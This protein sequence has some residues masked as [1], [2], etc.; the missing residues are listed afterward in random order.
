MLEKFDHPA[1][2]R[3]EQLFARPDWLYELTDTDIGEIDRAFQGVA[4]MDLE[5]ITQEDFSLPR[6]ATRMTAIQQSLESGSGATWVRGFPVERY[7][8]EQ[9][10]RVFWGLSRHVGT[11]VSQ[12]AEGERIFHVRDAGYGDQDPRTRG[13]N[14]RKKLSFHTDRCDVIS[15]LCLKQAKSGGE[16]FL[17]SSLALFN[18]LLERRPDLLQEL[19]RPY[20]YQRHNVDGGNALPYCRQPIFSIFEGH[21][22]ASFLRVLI[23]RAY[24]MPELPEMTDLQREALDYLEQLAEDPALHVRF[25][26]QAGDMLFLNNWVTFHRRSDF[27]DHETPERKRHLLRLWLSVPNSRPLDPQFRENF[28]ATEAGALRGGMRAR[29]A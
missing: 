8:D 16:N 4:Q 13:P 24:R 26:Q 14:T 28:G 22:A 1:A 12:S 19:M 10:M 2:W 25:R 11:P 9:A 20:Y 21:F 17:V 29:S 18:E 23:E 6:F 5:S 7:T 15:F 27:E 3:G